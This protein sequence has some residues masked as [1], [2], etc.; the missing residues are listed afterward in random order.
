MLPL[1][2]LPV[3]AVCYEKVINSVVD[4]KKK[5]NDALK[6][7]IDAIKQYKGHLD[8]LVNEEV[9]P[10]KREFI[11]N[12]NNQSPLLKVFI[13]SG[14]YTP[15]KDAEVIANKNQETI[16]RIEKFSLKYHWNQWLN[17]K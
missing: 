2:F 4:D 16:N 3:A 15:I 8:Q 11:S 13:S 12:L 7:Q 17:N 10:K 14:K 9:E 6:S 1:I 5:T